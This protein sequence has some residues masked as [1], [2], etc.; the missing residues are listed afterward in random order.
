MGEFNEETGSANIEAHSIVVQDRRATIRAT[1]STTPVNFW[2]NS[3]WRLFQESVMNLARALRIKVKEYPNSSYLDRWVLVEVSG[4]CHKCSARIEDCDQLFEELLGFEGHF[5]TPISSSSLEASPA[6]ESR[7]SRLSVMRQ[8][9]H[10]LN[11]SYL[12]AENIPKEPE[13]NPAGS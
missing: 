4:L 12:T 7:F 10:P 11:V 9:R 5:L 3:Q 13:D 1:A 2:C 8:Y 6:F